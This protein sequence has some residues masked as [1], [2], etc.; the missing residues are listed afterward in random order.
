M[1]F[2]TSRQRVY[3][4]TGSCSPSISFLLLIRLWKVEIGL[5]IIVKIA[6]AG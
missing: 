3:E 6:E 5:D 4:D 2:P 1:V